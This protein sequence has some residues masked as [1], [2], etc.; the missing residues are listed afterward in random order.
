[1]P[2]LSQEKCQKIAFEGDDRCEDQGPPNNVRINLTRYK[3]DCDCCANLQEF[4]GQKHKSSAHGC[5]ATQGQTRGEQRARQRN[6]DETP[7]GRLRVNW[8]HQQHEEA[9]CHPDDPLE[10]DYF[11]H[12]CCAATFNLDRIRV[13]RRVHV[14]L[15]NRQIIGVCTPPSQTKTAYFS[16]RFG[17]KVKAL[18]WESQC[19][20]AR[21]PAHPNY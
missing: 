7:S 17:A 16:H 21:R 10:S 1:M 3:H 15:T 11:P 12:I 8:G 19:A 18:L 5:F 4:S 2:Y 20:R 6:G 14:F 13:F 9:N